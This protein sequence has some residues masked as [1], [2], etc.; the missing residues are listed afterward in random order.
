MKFGKLTD[1]ELYEALKENGEIREKAF[2][3]LYSRYAKGVY[4]YCRRILGR[5]DLADDA[6]QEAFLNFL[7][8]AESDRKM[9]NVNAFLLRIARNVCLNENRRRRQ[10]ALS[11]D[12]FVL[13][14]EDDRVEKDEL[15]DLV[16]R[17]LDALKDEQKE[18]L[19]L[20]IYNGMS[21]QEIADF[22]GEPISTV[23]NRIARGKK[24]IREILA[25]YFEKLNS[26]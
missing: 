15:T 6:F 14:G 13:G 25:P 19:V 22:L 3:E 9:T 5:K 7:K 18:A 20:R 11:I 4:A 8:S 24:K 12:D 10:A 1:I 2:R 23:R 16:A 26:D 21:Y 17:S